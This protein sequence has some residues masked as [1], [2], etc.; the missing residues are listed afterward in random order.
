MFEFSAAQ[1]SQLN[2]QTSDG[3]SIPSIY[4]ATLGSY[5]AVCRHLPIDLQTA[6]EER[7]A[8]RDVVVCGDSR[9]ANDKLAKHIEQTANG[10]SK[11]CPPHPS[12]GRHALPHYQPLD[13]PPAGHTFY[14]T[15]RRKAKRS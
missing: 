7:K 8:G 11:Q 10:R 9:K 4:Q 6:I 13:R 2:V 14:E 3:S 12:A 15:D 1:I 5:G